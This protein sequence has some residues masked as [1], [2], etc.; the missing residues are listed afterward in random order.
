MA[1]KVLFLCLENIARFILPSLDETI[2]K[3][4]DIGNTIKMIN[5][6]YYL[7]QNEVVEFK[8]NAQNKKYRQKEKKAFSHNA[9]RDDKK[10]FWEAKN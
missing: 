6:N 1:L 2:W 3:D 5:R 4:L 8:S 9:K 7:E 10:R